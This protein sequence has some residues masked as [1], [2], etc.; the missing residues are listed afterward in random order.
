MSCKE[1]PASVGWSV[2]HSPHSRPVGVAWLVRYFTVKLQL[3]KTRRQALRQASF[4]Q[5]WRRRQPQLW[6]AR[7]RWGT[8]TCGCASRSRGSTRKCLRVS[9]DWRRCRR[10]PTA[11]PHPSATSAAPSLPFRSASSSRR[12]RRRGHAWRRRRR[13]SRSTGWVPSSQRRCRGRRRSGGRRR[14]SRRR[15]DLCLS[16]GLGPSFSPGPSFT[17]S[18]GLSLSLRLRLSLSLSLS[19]SLALTLTLTPNLTPTLTLAGE[20]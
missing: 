16:H 20:R 1:G 9:I 14:R 18:L 11:P 4:A 5:T 10:R 3:N 2:P 17:L 8:T 7:R 6:R 12:R 13:A 19:L 15:R